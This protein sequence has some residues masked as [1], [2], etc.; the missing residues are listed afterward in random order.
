MQ[1]PRTEETNHP[2]MNTLIARQMPRLS[3][4]AGSFITTSRW[5]E[6]IVVPTETGIHAD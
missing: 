3:P 6:D 4:I 1:F 2:T 5:R